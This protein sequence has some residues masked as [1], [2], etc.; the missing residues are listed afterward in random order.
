MAQ[1]THSWVDGA[2]PDSGFGIR[3]LPYGVCA[4]A[5]APAGAAGACCAAAGGSVLLLGELAR[6]GLL[7]AEAVAA[8]CEP[9]LNAFMALGRPAWRAVRARLQALLAADGEPGADAALRGDAALRARA[10]LPA[11]AV[12]LLLPARVGDYTDFYSSRDHAHNV[13]VMLRGAANALQPNWLWLPV[14]Y[15]GRASSV[16][17]SGTD[18][19]R[20]AGQLQ[21]DAAD[22]TKGAVLAPTKRLDFELEM[23]TW[24]GGPGSALGEPV[25]MA[26]AEEHVFGL[27]LMNDWSARDVQAWEYVPLGP[28]T[29]KN[30]ATSVSPW[31]VTL[32]ALEPFRCATSTGAQVP[33]PLPYLVDPRYETAGSFD[34]ALEV[35][36]LGAGWPAPHVVTRSNFKHMYWNLRQQLVHHTVSG[37]PLRPGDLLGSGTISGTVRRRARAGA[38]AGERGSRTLTPP[39]P[40][41]RRPTRAARCSSSRGRARRR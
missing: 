21:V 26:A 11:G 28:F 39:P 12:R 40:S 7:P 6:A 14:G 17:A 36:L 32:E 8:L 19:R 3:N 20:P 38:R 33:P 4:P 24:V 18:V 29:A 22:A 15:H 34:V 31:I 9:T 41:P 10:L 23:A 25:A 16:V 13:G 2:T 30:F 37:C 35:A 1:P 5:D 27:C